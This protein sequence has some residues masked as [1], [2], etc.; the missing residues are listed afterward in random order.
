MA[1]L[2]GGLAEGLKYNNTLNH[3]RW[4]GLGGSEQVVMMVIN[5]DKYN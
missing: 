3:L 4:L 2:C 5:S 1:G